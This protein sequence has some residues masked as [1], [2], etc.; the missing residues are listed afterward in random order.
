MSRRSL[1]LLAVPVLV[2]ALASP[3][4]ASKPDRQPLELPP[5]F[6]FGAGEVCSFAVHVEFLVNREKVT[7]FH[8]R[9]GDIVRVQ[10]TGSLVVRLSPVDDPDTSITVN[11]SGP[12]RHVFR[13]DG[14][15]TLTYAG[16][17]ISLYPP[18][19]LVF[20]AGQAVVE[21]NADGLFA[22]VTNI[23]FEADLCTALAPAG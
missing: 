20:T 14:T 17:S 21:L 4:A 16:R 2:L 18:G 9:A 15:S 19:T 12:S 8:N 7:T 23:G 1:A 3:V 11:I 10:T 5:E 13:P 6:D 22:S